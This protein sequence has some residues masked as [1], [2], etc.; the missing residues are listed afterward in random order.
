MGPGGI[1]NHSFLENYNKVWSAGR[2]TANGF[3]KDWSTHYLIV[4]RGYPCKVSGEEPLSSVTTAPVNLHCVWHYS[5]NARAVL[6]GSPYG[7]QE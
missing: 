3:V 5:I 2:A 4:A 1:H 7:N 6:G